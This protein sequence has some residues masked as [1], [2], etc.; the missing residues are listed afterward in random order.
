MKSKYWDTLEL[1]AVLRRL[2]GYA[3][4]SAGKALAAALTPLSDPDEVRR[5]QAQ[6]AEARRLLEIKSDITMGGVHDVRPLMDNALLGARLLPQDLLNIR[7]TLRRARL[8][9]R[10]IDRQKEEFPL[11][12]AITA[13]LSP[14]LDVVA[15]IERCIDDYGEVLDSASPALSRLRSALK[16]ARDRLMDKLNRLVANPDNASHLQEGYIT[17]RNGRYVVPLRAQSRGRIPG[18]IHDQSSSGATLFVEPLATVDLNNRCRE[19]ELQEQREVE[20]ILLALSALAAQEAESI[21]ATVAALAQLDLI[22]ARARYA[23]A[24][25]ATQPE[26]VPF[27]KPRVE[28]RRRGRKKEGAPPVHPGSVVDLRQ[29]RHPLLDPQRVVPID[30]RLDRASGDHVIVITG[31]NTGG[32]TV[33]LKTVGLLA[34]MAQCGLHLPVQEGSR[35]TV[36]EH[37][38]ADIGDEQSIEQS[39][40]TFSSHL[41]NIIDIL[42]SVD[43]RSLVLLDELGAGTDPVEGAA[44]AQSL[45]IHLLQ[46]RVTAL[47]TT[48][49]PELKLFAHNTPGVTNA[50]VEF[51]VETLSPTYQLT[52]GLPGRSNAFAIAARLGLSNVIVRRAR[53]MVAGDALDVERYLAEIKTLRERAEQTRLEVEQQRAEAAALRR[54]LGERLAQIERERDVILDRA[55]EQAV[56]EVDALRKELRALRRRVSPADRARADWAAVD[57]QLT[58]L[59]E[60]M[61]VDEPAALTV[62]ALPTD[63]EI[64]I[65]DTVWVPDLNAAGELVALDDAVAQVQVGAFRVRTRKRGLELRRKKSQQPAQ[66]TDSLLSLP[67]APA[68]SL[69]I[70]LRGLRVDEGLR[71]LTKYLD[72]AYRAQAPFVR[73]VH[74]KGSG[75]MKKAVRGMLR[76][77]PL[78][79][80]FRDGQEGE[81]DTGVTIARFEQEVGA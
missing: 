37:I 39:L 31:P 18:L 36:F 45:L 47:V 52:I 5:R 32:K 40:S 29:A 49:H 41:T 77:H 3:S 16:V 81:G 74:G 38:C 28:R 62:A 71:R 42:E 79:A 21:K 67:P 60:G 66:T 20:R 56:Q 80:S 57:E 12:V 54:E 4:F 7:D 9:R 27:S 63:V 70:H 50:C 17:Q 59:S 75:R 51:D 43:D 22:L 55:R 11:L 72:D 19:L 1:P 65:G 24:I 69:E 34:L 68:V 78:I 53:G 25:Q 64:E 44:L 10:S 30:V 2:E 15:E 23:D 58:R 46:R 35:L 76:T 13:Q 6:T 8:L 61:A 73:I 33:S 26:I 14:C 48:H